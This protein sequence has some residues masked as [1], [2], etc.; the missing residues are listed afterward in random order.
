MKKFD[1]RFIIFVLLFVLCSCSEEHINDVNSGVDERSIDITVDATLCADDH[2]ELDLGYANGERSI[3]DFAVDGAGVYILQHDSTVLHYD[4]SGRFIERYDLN[5]AEQGLT[6]SR[7]AYSNGKI[8]LLDGHN[9]AI[10]TAEND[11]IKNVS[12]LN[13]SDVGMLKNFY[14]QESGTLVMSFSDIDEPYT[15]EVD[16]TGKETEIVGEKQKGYLIGENITYLPELI[17]DNDETSK[18]KVTIYSSGEQIGKFTIG[19]K[20]K[21]RSMLGLSIYGISHDEWFGI[22]HEFVNYGEDPGGE[23]YV[24]TSVSIDTKD[25]KIKTSENHFNDDEIIKLSKDDTY[26]MSFTDNALTIRPISEYF[27]DWSDSDIYFLTN[28]QT[29]NIRF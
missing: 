16:P 14:A 18:V 17:N 29:E 7:I 25:E 26:C 8:Y 15:V 11:K 5:L 6:A 9:N 2:A 19:T 3:R 13:F 1:C 10:I 21:S 22:L 23:E 4:K 28:D 27:S 24:K 12:L 20:E